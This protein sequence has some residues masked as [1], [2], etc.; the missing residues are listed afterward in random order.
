MN[1]TDQKKERAGRSRLLVF[2]VPPLS[3]AGYEIPPG[4]RTACVC[5]SLRKF[6]TPPTIPRQE[7]ER[8]GKKEV[9]GRERQTQHTECSGE[10]RRCKKTTPSLHYTG[11]LD[12]PFSNSELRTSLRQE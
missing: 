2:L 12:N 11:L 6:E 1:M 3:N 10:R 4:H 7:I 8:E 5:N 9:Q